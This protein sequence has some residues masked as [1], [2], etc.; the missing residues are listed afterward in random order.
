MEKNNQPL[1][2]TAMVVGATLI[3][4]LALIFTRGSDDAATKTASDTSEK[5]ENENS[6]GQQLAPEPQ[7]GILPADWDS[8]TSREKTNLNPFGCDHETQ[9]V[10]AED[11]SCIEKQPSLNPD[12]TV[13][14]PEGYITCLEG[15][16]NPNCIAETP[17]G[18]N[19]CLEGFHGSLARLPDNVAQFLDS[20]GYRECYH[21]VVGGE[22]LA[23]SKCTES[24]DARESDW[25]GNIILV[26]PIRIPILTR[27]YSPEYPG[28]VIGDYLY[29]VDASTGV[30]DDPQAFESFMQVL[31]VLGIQYEHPSA[32]LTCGGNGTEADVCVPTPIPWL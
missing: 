8:L 25:R 21:F 14:T 12:C 24:Q 23:Y 5:Q 30:D 13:E 11:G 26:S 16:H 22:Q 29:T 10:S 15:F 19:T 4:A 6:D 28:V 9:G 32:L 20:M 27:A 1:I 18:Y 7:P 31:D 2:I 3:I 17:E